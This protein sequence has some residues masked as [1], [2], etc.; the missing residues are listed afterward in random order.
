MQ[1]LENYS[2]KIYEKDVILVI[3]YNVANLTSLYIY[4]LKLF[5]AFLMVKSI[6]RVS[7]LS[8]EYE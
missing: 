1:N 6:L 5:K 4:L 7:L 3:N 8:P 2:I